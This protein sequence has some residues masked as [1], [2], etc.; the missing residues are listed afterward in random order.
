M[1]Y[2]DIRTKIRAVIL[3]SVGVIVA[4]LFLRVALDLISASDNNIL[5][6]LINSITDFF[7]SPFK[8]VIEIPED[9]GI[10][11]LNVDALVAA[12]VYVLCG[13]AL[14]EI[15]T[16]FVYEKVE[17]IFQNFVDGLFKILE[18]L[19][20]LRIV[21]YFFDIGLNRS[22]APSFIKIVYDLTDWTQSTGL[23]ITFLKDYLDWN[24]IVILTI[25]VVLDLLAERFL[26]SIF[27]RIET[28][29]ARIKPQPKPPGPVAPALSVSTP[30]PQP[31]Q[32]IVNVPVPPVQ[33]IP[34]PVSQP[35]PQP[36]LNVNITNPIPVQYNPPSQSVSQAPQYGVPSQNIRVDPN[37]VK[38]VTG[39]AAAG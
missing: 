2:A 24:A 39:P 35:V 17:D 14:S 28:T 5:V 23:G 12:L 27:K 19:I 13:I 33:Q 29:Y 38:E 16:A 18:F 9:T 15:V 4:L 1:D 8:N 22:I 6:G 3:T 32:I 34:V 37:G 26:D 31:Q 21:F 36:P 20:L 25:I 7:A 10:D 11:N 30:L